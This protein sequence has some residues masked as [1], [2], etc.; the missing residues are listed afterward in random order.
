[1]N[2]LLPLAALLAVIAAPAFADTTAFY[3]APQ[4]GAEMTVEV[5]SNG[6][7]RSTMGGRGDYSLTIGGKSYFVFSTDKGLV[8]DDVDDVTAALADYMKAKMPEFAKFPD[9]D[10]PKFVPAG[11]LTINGR[12]GTVWYSL[13]D[14]KMNARM[15]MVI[16]ADPKLGELARAM[17][18]SYEKSIAMFGQAFGRSKLADGTLKALRTGAPL[19]FSGVDLVSVSYAPI[20]AERFVLPAH[21]ETREQV[22]ARLA[23][24]GGHIP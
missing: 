1:V 17:A 18:D 9:F 13:F 14:G 4:S 20:A 7:V 15:S 12:A 21:P 3:K 16:S 11:T 6:D 8:V 19:R 22:V 10:G 2:P 5:A 24:S 23:A